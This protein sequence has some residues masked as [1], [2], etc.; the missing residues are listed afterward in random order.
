MKPTDKSIALEVLDGQIGESKNLRKMSP[1][2]MISAG[3]FLAVNVFG[4]RASTEDIDYIL[5]PEIKNLTKA[6]EKL[7][8]A[9]RKVNK[10][11]QLEDQ[12][13]NDSMA[14]FAVG[15]KRKQ[16]FRESVEQNE[17]VFQGKHLVIYAVKWQWGL[18]RKLIR[19]G[20]SLGRKE[21][22]DLSDAVALI[23]R[24]VEQEGTALDRNMVKSWTDNIYTP[25]EDQVL[26]RVAAEYVKKYG[27]QCFL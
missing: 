1:V 4:N 22:I 9:I 6:E 21:D 19:L 14:V 3:G 23:R 18:T 27:T 20:A 11:L 5:D 25:I 26:D 8:I 15:D 17:V 10:D 24:I 7:S 16:L 2:R 13:I 12:W